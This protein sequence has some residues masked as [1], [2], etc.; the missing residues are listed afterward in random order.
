MYNINKN[1]WKV[2]LIKKIT[3]SFHK[4]K[5]EWHSRV[6]GHKH[7]KGTKEARKITKEVR[8]M[9]KLEKQKKKKK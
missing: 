9:K 7:N 6:S 4:F 5:Q 8:K 2:T 3:K 1:A